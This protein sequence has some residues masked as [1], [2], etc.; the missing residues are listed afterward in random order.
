MNHDA[1]SHADDLTYARALAQGE[2]AAVLRFEREDRRVVRHALGRAL[3]RWRPETPVE[4]DDLVQD[5][6]GHLFSDGGRRLRTYQGRSAFRGWLYTVALRFFQR[7]LA[8]RRHDRRGDE[9]VLARLPS[10]AEDPE[11]AAARGERA[12][13]VRA[14]VA[15]LPAEDQLLVRLFFIDGLNASEVARTLGAGRSA[16]RMRKMRLLERLRAVLEPGEAP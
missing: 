5:F 12:A 9:A 11:Q 15:S 6:V 2:P 13:A 4:P 16:T 3:A 1:P 8:R 14:L 10:D 7:Q